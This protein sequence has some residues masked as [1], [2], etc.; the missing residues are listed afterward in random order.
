MLMMTL[1]VMITLAKGSPT[2]NIT[3]WSLLEKVTLALMQTCLCHAYLAL[4]YDDDT[5]GGPDLECVRMEM[6]L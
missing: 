5:S 2:Q 3:Y 1:V 6:G 4:V